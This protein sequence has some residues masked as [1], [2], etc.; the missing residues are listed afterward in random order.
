M[1]ALSGI[2]YENIHPKACTFKISRASRKFE[3]NA[4]CT[5]TYL[6]TLTSIFSN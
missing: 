5:P 2:V 6:A 1:D 4:T 3:V